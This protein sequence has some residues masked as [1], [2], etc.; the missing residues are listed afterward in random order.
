LQGAIFGW[1]KIAA[2]DRRG[3]DEHRCGGDIGGEAVD[4]LLKRLRR[5]HIDL[6]QKRVFSHDALIRRTLRLRDLG[7]D[8][9]EVLDVEHALNLSHLPT[10]RRLRDVHT[11]ASS[12][13]IPRFCDRVDGRAVPVQHRQPQI[14]LF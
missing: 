8:S 9:L 10:D 3:E 4:D 13:D 12:G 1:L 7:R 11:L 14:P 6:L 5:G 2:R